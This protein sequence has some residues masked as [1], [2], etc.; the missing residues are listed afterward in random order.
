M[1]LHVQLSCR[2]RSL[3]SF[4]LVES[5]QR[6]FKSTTKKTRISINA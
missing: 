2:N 4:M 1:N 3:V 5:I 6:G